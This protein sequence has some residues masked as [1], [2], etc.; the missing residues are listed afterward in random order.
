MTGGYVYRGKALPALVGRYLFS[1][2]CTGV[3][4]SL[5]RDAEGRAVANT[6][7]RTGFAVSSFGED[8]AGEL[9][10]CDHGGGRVLRFVR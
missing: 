3:V 6:V 4:Y 7:V 2:Y 9:Y 1:D 5:M 8:E 10:L